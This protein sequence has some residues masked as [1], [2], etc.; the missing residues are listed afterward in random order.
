MHME[1]H[2]NDWHPRWRPE[3]REEW[4][5]IL[6]IDDRIVMVGVPLQMTCCRQVDTEAA[7]LPYDEIPVRTVVRRRALIRRCEQGQQSSSTGEPLRDLFR[8]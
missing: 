1:D 7:A 5:S 8:K 3:R 4:D 2:A 6:E